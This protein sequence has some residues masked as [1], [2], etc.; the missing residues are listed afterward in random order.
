MFKCTRLFREFHPGILEIPEIWTDGNF[1]VDP[2]YSRLMIFTFLF[3]IQSYHTHMHKNSHA[4]TR[5]RLAKT[6]R[7]SENRAWLKKVEAAS[8]L[9]VKGLSLPA[10]THM[11]VRSCIQCTSQRVFNVIQNKNGKKNCGKRIMF[12][13]QKKWENMLWKTAT[14]A[15]GQSG[16]DLVEKL[17]PGPRSHYS[18]CSYTHE[19]YSLEETVTECGGLPSKS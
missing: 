6:T 18:E 3:I 12:V 10:H 14:V 15:Q 16:P 7:N 19:S 13:T 5:V 4:H 2:R 17:W 1:F 8:L 11:H 9:Q